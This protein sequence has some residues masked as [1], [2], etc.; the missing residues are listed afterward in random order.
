MLKYGWHFWMKYTVETQGGNMNKIKKIAF[1]VGASAIAFVGTMFGDFSNDSMLNVDAAAK[2]SEVELRFL[3][4]TDLHGQLNSVD[5]EQGIN[6]KN[7]GLARVYDLITNARNELPQGN[8]LTFDVGDVMYDYTTEYI[9]S[10][11]QTEIQPIFK[12]MEMIGYDAITMGNHEFDYGFDYM[13]NQYKGSGLMDKVVVSNVVDSK[14]EEYPFLENMLITREFDTT[15]GE[16]VELTIG[17]IGE[18]IPTLTEKVQTYTGVLK[19]EDMVVNVTK[20]SAKLKE[21]GADLIIVLAH[22]GIGPEQPEEN[23]K[24]VA[25]A[26]ST[27]EDVD[28]IFCGHEHN[29]FPTTDKTSAY[30]SLPDVDKTTYL[31]NGKNVVMA[32]DRGRAL[33][34]VDLTVSIE[35]GEIS[36][37]DRTS[38]LRYVSDYNTTE[39][40]EMSSLYGTYEDDF[41]KY[42]KEVVGTLNEGD[43]IN[44]Y[45]G[46]FQ[47]NTLIQLL[48]DA[49]MSH[50]IRYINT[51]GTQYKNY[52]VLAVSTYNTFGLSTDTEYVVIED[53]FTE[54]NL[55]AMQLYNSYLYLYTITGEQLK[56][57]LEWSASAFEVTSTN[58]KW[59][60]RTMSELMNATNLKSLIKEEWLEDFSNFYIF[61]GIDYEINPTYQPR[62]DLSGNKISNSSRVRNITYNGVSITNDMV[63]ILASDKVTKP[64]QANKGIETQA[65]FKKFY[66]GQSVLSDYIQMLGKANDILPT[67]D[68]NWR[69]QLSEKYEFIVNGPSDAKSLAEASSWFKKFIKTVDGSS[70]F[71]GTGITTTTDTLAPNLLVVPTNMEMTGA[72]YEVAIHATDLSG[73]KVIKYLMGDYDADDKRWESTSTWKSN[74]FPVKENGIYSVY[75]EDNY[76]NTVV[77]KVS[78]DNISDQVVGEPKVVTYTNR[79][80][81]I[82]GTAEP[83][84]TVVFEAYTGTYKTKANNSGNFSYALPAQPS[85]SKMTV[86]A[87]DEAS[88]ILSKKVTLSVKRTGPNQ[89]TVNSI[90]N[91]SN[92]V[93][94]NLN[95]DDATVIVIAD[96]IVYVPSNGGKELF[97]NATEIY[98]D[99]YTI[100]EMDY[101]VDGNQFVLYIKPQTVGTSLTV[102]TIDHVNRMSRVVT[103]TV[104]DGGPNMPQVYEVSNIET[105]LRGN[106]T[107]SIKNTIFDVYAKVG[108]QVYQVQSDKKGNFI[109]EFDQPLI[110]DQVIS[111]YA[112]DVVNGS[113]R[114]SLSAELVVQDINDYVQ[115]N[116]DVFSI[117]SLNNRDTFVYG[118][119]YDTDVELY[120]GI[121]YK[122][123]G[124]ISKVEVGNV[125]TDFVGDFEYTLSSTLP[126][127]TEV[128]A[129]TRFVDGEIITVVKTVVRPTIPAKPILMD[130]ITNN[131]KKVYVVTDEECLV[132]IEIGTKT[133]T[134]STYVYDSELLSYVYTVDVGRAN[135]TTKYSIYASNTAGISKS[136]T[137]KISKSAPD[138]PKVED[139]T[140]SSTTVVGSISEFK[141]ETMEEV[142]VY[143]QIGDKKYSTSVDEEGKFSFEI[144]EQKEKKVL[145]LWASN[146]NGLGPRTKVVVKA[147]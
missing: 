121:C 143:L 109:F 49:K 120:L 138:A 7:G 97:E 75:A 18:T 52:P 104:L 12:A 93:Y 131:T 122:Q 16:T 8:T 76:G 62:Y 54:A 110:K 46:L 137:G 103:K 135:S 111:V 133:Y 72:G 127:G 45:F 114:R 91:N 63:F 77:R 147:K 68:N 50:A 124:A 98:S 43:S 83:G 44:N 79:K 64:T 47:D 28:V 38:S 24:N 115:S 113:R 74:T 17:I 65:V 126:V 40:K 6:F 67:P 27:I 96:T 108:N 92:Y 81:K 139:V 39:N 22:T 34:V 53:E 35:D 1:V 58:T 102:Y 31:M 84:I 118:N 85:G 129:M 145:Y 100:V 29:S 42:A 140:T 125:T 71:V 25:Y 5:Y 15:D 10:M 82:T 119:Y 112:T 88:G 101:K 123:S 128:Y 33:G 106:V 57:W 9:F 11:D 66:R 90:Y 78:I 21:Q 2:T 19:T 13:V 95:D 30:F 23:F 60:N 87:K 51:E 37:V 4:T 61:D 142:T 48:N 55:A 32:A 20:Q 94:G 136:L 14:T 130:E 70:Y 89:P 144:K 73:I 107:S 80:T 3:A 132:T 59:T 141:D 116:S 146:E 86:Y 105:S 36:I 134:S 56:E 69:L 99:K 26:L 41:L 117:N